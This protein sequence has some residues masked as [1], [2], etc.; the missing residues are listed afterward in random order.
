VSSAAGCENG[1]PI[2]FAPVGLGLGSPGRILFLFVVR[3][4]GARRRF[5]VMGVLGALD[6]RAHS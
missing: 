6:R 2:G 1:P 4:A 3:A 5:A